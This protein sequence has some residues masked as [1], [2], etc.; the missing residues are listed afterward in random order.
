MKKLLLSLTIVSLLL[1][2][3]SGEVGPPGPPG[4]DGVNILGQIFEVEV[5]FNSNNDYKVLV[6]I[7][8]EIEVF[9]TDVIVAYVLTDVIDDVDVWEPLPQSLF[10]GGETLLYGFNYTF[11]D[12]EFFLDGTVFL[13]NLPPEFTQDLIFR[14]AVIPADAAQNLD[15]QNM[16]NVINSFKNQEILRVK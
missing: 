15:L 6:D 4:Q 14:V 13:D 12:V 3:C 16:E 9:D 8:S 11:S 2:S 1:I 10:L 5:D 7:P